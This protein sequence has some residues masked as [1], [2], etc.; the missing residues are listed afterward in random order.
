MES[1]LEGAMAAA[2]CLAMAVQL[3]RL[4]KGKV[5]SQGR[6]RAVG[7]TIGAGFAVG[8]VRAVLM[9]ERPV[10]LILYLLGFMLAYTD[11]IWTTA[12]RKAGKAYE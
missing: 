1:L 5:Q 8:V 11:V 6:M 4:V 10:L 9:G 3:Y 2:F 7:I 12:E